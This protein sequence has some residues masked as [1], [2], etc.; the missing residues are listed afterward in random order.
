MTGRQPGDTS[1]RPKLAQTL[2]DTIEDEIREQGW[3]VGAFLGN[4]T[5]LLER[6]GVSRAALRE[7]IRILES[8]FIA[9]M[10]PGPGGGLVV[11]KPD[12]E[13]ITR[14]MAR[15]LEFDDVSE[16]D[17]LQ[18][19]TAVEL[20]CLD[21]VM[22][23]EDDVAINALLDYVKEEEELLRSDGPH[24]GHE[25]HLR[26]AELS[27]NDALSLFVQVLVRISDARFGA[28]SHGAV[29]CDAMSSAT[30]RIHQRIVRAIS[31]GDHA[32]AVKYMRRH[33]RATEAFW[34]AERG[35]AT[36]TRRAST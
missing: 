15:Q 5:E 31:E 35:A 18:A 32:E 27:G 3:K 6:H 1:S 17:I 2:A 36:L 34:A 28:Q 24:V 30:H 10:K 8:N 11:V 29:S 20:A 9:K 22:S 4:E 23:R 21:L 33:L 14:A 19:R 7:S 26:L 12:P 25:F 13:T 16:T